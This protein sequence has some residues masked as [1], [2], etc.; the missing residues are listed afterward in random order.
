MEC[1]GIKPGKIFVC[2]ILPLADSIPVDIRGGGHP[3][4]QLRVES[5]INPAL[6][7]LAEELKLNFID[8]YSLF[9]KAD[10]GRKELYDGIHPYDSG[11]ALI[12]MAIYEELHNIF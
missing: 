1:K 4:K 7:E 3:W 8:I 2:S 5:E 9:K 11:Y 12:G 10:G 6:K